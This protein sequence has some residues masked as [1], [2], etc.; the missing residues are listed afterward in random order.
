V[1]PP[2]S[3]RSAGASAA[4][5]YGGW[6]AAHLV[7]TP[8]PAALF[9]ISGAYAWSHA[10][11]GL[12]R[13]RI[14]ERIDVRDA[15]EAVTALGGR[16]DFYRE[17]RGGLVPL[18][19]RPVL[20]RL[21]PAGPEVL[22]TRALRPG[23]VRM[24]FA[25]TDLGGSAGWWWLSDVLAGVALGGVFPSRIA[26][27]IEF[28][29]SGTRAG[30]GPLRLPSGRVVDPRSE[31][32]CAVARVERQRVTTDGHR[33]EWERELLA[34]MHRLIGSVLAFGNPARIDRDT[35]RTPVL[36][37]VIGPDGRRLSHR[38]VHPEI[39]GPHLDLLVAGV[40]TAR[41]RLAMAASVGAIEAAG[42][43]W[44]HVATDSVLAAV[45]PH[46]EAEFVPCH[47]GPHRRGH[48]RGILALPL[49]QVREL[50]ERTGAPWRCQVGG[51]QSMTGYVSGVYRYALVDPVSGKATASEA[52][53]G[54]I[55]SDPTGTEA[56][57]SEGHLAWAVEGHLAVARAG[58]AWD[59]RSAVPELVLPSWADLAVVRPGVARTPEQ[60]SRIERAFPHR[61]V[62]PF[63][64]FLQAV[65]DP[66]RGHGVVPIT[67]DVDTRPEDRLR[68]HWVDQ[69]N[70]EQ[71]AL[72]TSE[73][74][75]SGE[76]RVRTYRELLQ[77]WR[78]VRDPTT[79]PVEA[80]DHVLQPG[81]RQA[82]PVRSSAE[83]VELCG[84]EGDDLYSL[85]VDPMASTGDVLT[86]YR[87]PD[88]WVSVLDAA[89]SIGAKE[90]QRRSGLGRTTIYAVLTGRR[91]SVET[92][93]LFAQ[94][95]G[96][97]AER[98]PPVSKMCARPGCPRAVRRRQRW[99]SDRCRKATSRAR[100]RLA[101]R[102][103]GATRCQ[104][105]AGVRFG[106]A[107]GPCPIC[108]GLGVV[109]A[110]SHR[111]SNC[112]VERVGDT[113]GPCPFCRAEAAS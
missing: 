5:F 13:F 7:H 12:Q 102:E 11:Q 17:L 46:D 96:E 44:L 19:G 108:H 111:C 78:L 75:E 77:L 106:D 62:R 73:V 36:D 48:R 93:A 89:R 61:R 49:S 101:L 30:I 4:A 91:P 69:R 92:A 39:P 57:T 90:L 38:S 100:D 98:P 84:K 8:V 94:V 24:A 72:T 28:V 55:Y 15:T 110:I 64:P 82:V 56:R 95:V 26:E 53:L 59:G 105:C 65:V 76:V 85:M 51:D 58:I 3:D 60:L 71:V 80:V 83:L 113:S 70:G 109:E 68:A 2:H 25:P 99:C 33:P 103:I 50:L 67:L 52:A 54:G 32:L 18:S 16:D 79:E 9:D 34:G 1:T 21:V 27:A 22:P 97:M 63:T 47:G 81:L 86:I 37:E 112:G 23:G 20:V 43:A 6:S 42:G 107:T 104:T 10:D 74:P 88:T 45:T 31:D 14:A 40:V 41:V 66:L 35:R 29:A 87:R